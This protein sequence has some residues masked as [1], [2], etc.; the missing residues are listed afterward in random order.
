MGKKSLKIVQI[1]MVDFGSTGKIMLQIAKAARNQGVEML[2]LSTRQQAKRYTPMPQAPEGHAY[3]GSFIGNNLHFVLARITGKYGCYSRY[4]TFK[5]LRKLKAIKPDLI[6][7]HNLHAAYLNLEMLV[8]YINKEHIPVV[9]TLHDCWAFTGKCP[10]F[11][12]IG[13]EKW[14]TGCFDCPQLSNYPQS[15][16]DCSKAMWQRKKQWFTSIEEL[17]LVTPS[18]WLAGLV[19][20]SFLKNASVRVINNGIDLSVFKPTES[21]FRKKYHCEDKYVLLGVAFGWGVRK[22]LDVFVEL[23]SRL[24]KSYQIV[25]VGTDEHIEK[26]LP[27]S[28]IPIRRT[29][30]QQELAQIYSAADLFINPTRE[31]NYP[32]VNMEALACGTP[33]LTFRTGGSPEILDKTCGNVVECDDLQ[34]LIHEIRRIKE[35][36]PYSENACLDRSKSFDMHQRFN[37]YLELYKKCTENN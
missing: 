21:D 23:A 27:G 33:V 16:L 7:L 9:W 29:H 36:V 12:L 15:R 35:T 1:N 8:R 6:H 5:M 37:E 20:Q 32:T 22:G 3:Y 10:H 14:K 17:T 34:G 25:L 18:E 2:T 4:S 26:Q 13:C 31:E 24:D 19:K 28:I 11:D 30:S